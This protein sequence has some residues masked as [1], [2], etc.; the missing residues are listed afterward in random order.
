MKKILLTMAFVLT[1]LGNAWADDVTVGNIDIPQ[2]STATLSISLEN[3]KDYRQLF[4]FVLELPEGITVVSNSAKL[5]MDRFNDKADLSC[6]EPTTRNY[7]FLCQAG[8]DISSIGGNSGVIVTV[9]LLADASLEQSSTPLKGT[10]KEIEVT[11]Q[12]TK[13][14]SPSDKEFDI[15]IV[16]PLT[17]ITLDENSTTVP[18]GIKGVDVEVLR[19]INANEWSTISLPFAMT[20]ADVVSAFGS[21][22]KIANFSSWSFEG[23]PDNV[24]NITINFTSV[25]PQGGL[26]AN[27]PYMIKVTSLVSQFNAYNVNIIKQNSPK[28][29]KS[30]SYDGDD[31]EAIMYGYNKKTDVENRF[32]VSENKFWF[33][34]E[35]TIKAFRAAFGFDDITLA[36]DASSRMTMNFIDEATAIN[37]VDADDDSSDEYY[38]LQGQRV[39]TPAKGVFI[40]GGKK[41]LVK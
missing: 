26:E 15:T 13:A 5:N 36:E 6:T 32:F 27:I 34:E 33:S 17:K 37:A 14:F 1:A 16:A 11:D 23:E 19:T 21:D 25:N 30:F 41:I 10:L 2:G 38:N 29:R 31:Y 35:V 8:T 9:L 40:K 20:G 7:Q 12:D 28:L 22:V 4:Q 3:S 24:T 18:S 39:D